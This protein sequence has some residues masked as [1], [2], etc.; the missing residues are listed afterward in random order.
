M[1]KIV[2]LIGYKP[3]GKQT[4][5]VPINAVGSADMAIANYTIR[6][7][8]YFLADGFQYN[9]IDDYSFNKTTTGSEVI[10]TLNDSVILYQGSIKEYPDYTAQGEEFE[11]V[12]IVVKNVSTSLSFAQQGLSYKRPNLHFALDQ[13][14]WDHVQTDTLQIETPVYQCC[15][16]M[17]IHL[18]KTG[19]VFRL[20][21]YRSLNNQ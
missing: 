5:I 2:K 20:A 11:L 17:P 13:F 7:N 14:A 8:S 21:L 6:K 3:A 1:N 4:S 16:H 18:H 10:K 9:F 19:H 12:P 15:F